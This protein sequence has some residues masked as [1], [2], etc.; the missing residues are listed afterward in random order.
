MSARLALLAGLLVAAGAAAW[1]WWFVRCERDCIAAERHAQELF[2]RGELL[3]ALA[4]IDQV[5]AR[6]NC[7]R[8]TSGDAPPHYSLAV[9]CVRQ[10]RG[11]GRSLEVQDL[12]EHARGPILKELAGEKHNDPR[13]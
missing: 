1:W 2:Q 10:L 13:N 11:E 3:P 6:C 12:L 7:A 9:V 8:F 5:D 4:L